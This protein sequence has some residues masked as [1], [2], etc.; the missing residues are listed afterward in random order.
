MA[1]LSRLTRIAG[2]GLALS[3]GL[4]AG[5]D[6]GFAFKMGGGPLDGSARQLLGDAGY[7]FGA[8]L[9][10]SWQLKNGASIVGG[11][12]IRFMPGDFRVVSSIPSTLPSR[13][14]PGTYYAVGQVDKGEA[15]SFNVSAVYRHS[16]F[17]EDMYW[18]GGLILS[19]SKTEITSTGTRLTI[20]TTAPNTA[21]SVTASTAI[22][23]TDSKNATSLNFTGGLGYRFGERYALEFNAFTTRLETS[24][25]KKSG[26][27]TS[28]D[29]SVRF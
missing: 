27:G 22:A 11:F 25:T 6:N 23:T 28:L 17:T 24:T 4:A 1:S 26:L 16:A 2:L 29:F 10:H 5:D 3:C 9:E 12:G 18:H 19:S 8:S 13:A 15:R 7:N 20:V 21:G 14:T